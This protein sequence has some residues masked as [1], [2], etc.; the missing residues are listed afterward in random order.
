[1]L[2]SHA[3]DIPFALL[4][5]ID[6]DGRQARL[7]G[8]VGISDDAMRQPAIALG[9]ESESAGG[10]PLAKAVHTEAILTVED[11]ASRFA[12]VPPGPW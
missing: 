10:W 11:L 4:Y 8:S 7:A 2:A 3:K 5:L 12:A 6:A 9:E 1:M